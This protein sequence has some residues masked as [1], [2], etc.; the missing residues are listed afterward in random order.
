[1]GFQG[2]TVIIG[3]GVDIAHFVQNHFEKKSDDIFLVTTSR[4]VHKNAVDEVIRALVLLAGIDSFFV[5]GVG[6]D[7]TNVE[8][9]LP[10]NSEFRLAWNGKDMLN[11][12]IYL[13]HSP[14]ATFSF[15]HRA[16]KEWEILLLKRWR[17]ITGHRDARRRYRGFSF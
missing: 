5:Y 12:K 3:N 4:L 7:E 14:G 8:S 6:P 13:R 15:V 1:M 9:I 17:R 10:K 16:Q 11:I 2:E